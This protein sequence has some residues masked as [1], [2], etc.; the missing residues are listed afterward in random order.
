M[1]WAEFAREVLRRALEAFGRADAPAVAPYLA[2]GR[3]GEELAAEYL[4][5]VG[6]EL[7]AAN[8]EL[9]VGRDRRGAVVQAELDIV[10]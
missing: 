6:Y 2:L 9:G 5:G 3:R 7:V 1:R 10:A 4:Q 8:F